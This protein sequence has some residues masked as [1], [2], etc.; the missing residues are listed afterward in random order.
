MKKKL[1]AA[2]TAAVLSFG[3]IAASAAFEDV[4]ADSWYADAVDFMT[5]SGY[6]NGISD[7]EFNPDGGMTR[8]MFV[9]VLGRMDGVYTANYTKAIFPDVTMEQWYAPYVSWALEAGIVT[10]YSDLRFRPNEQI[11]REQLAAMIKRY[12]DYRGIALPENPN[13]YDSFLDESSIPDWAKDGAALM[14][15]TGVITGDEYGSFMPS[16]PAT[17][18]QIAVIIMKLRSVMNGETLEIPRRKEHSR[19]ETY[20]SSMSLRDK[21]YQMLLVN[22]EQITGVEAA[23][24]AG[25]MTKEAVAKYPV[26]GL[27]YGSKNIIDAAQIKEMLLSTS[28]FMTVSPFTA[29]SEEPGDFSQLSSKLNVAKYNNAYT[30][31]NDGTEKISEIYG[32]ISQELKN[33]GFNTNLAPVADAWS[34]T[35]N[36]YIAT[37]AFSN[38]YLTAAAMTEA[39]I[40]ASKD[41]GVLTA[42]KYFPGYGDCAENP[43]DGVCYSYKTLDDLKNEDFNAYKKGIDAGCDFVMC[44]NVNMPEIDPYYP[45][46]LSTIFVNDLL[47]NHLGFNG[48]IMSGDLSMKAVTS[49]YSSADAAVMAVD[50]GCDM[51]LTPENP[52]QAADA[53]IAAVN[54]KSITETRINESVL[55]IL[56]KKLEAGI[57]Q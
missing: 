6:M 52:E 4:P 46:S 18:A 53:I 40:S 7:S 43:N 30:Y 11:N 36:G 12:V 21:V 35:R 16:E 26:G 31:R 34:N 48:I 54:G 56:E 51:L 25:A 2:L 10:G 45:A 24:I 5:Q 33:L 32:G 50:A 41:K 1:I 47:K 20:L 22:P 15:T 39:A 57:L 19:A 27:V 17:R 55:K 29:I 13:A 9:T 3:S 42:M 44:A 23:T 38:D 37:R 14:R 28:G 49:K 8:G